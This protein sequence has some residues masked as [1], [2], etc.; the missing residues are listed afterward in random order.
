[1]TYRWLSQD[2]LTW[3][4]NGKNW[5]SS[6]EN[7]SPQQLYNYFNFIYS[8]QN[9]KYFLYRSYQKGREGWW[10]DTEPPSHDKDAHG[11]EK[12]ILGNV[13]AAIAPNGHFY[14]TFHQRRVD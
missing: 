8:I 10:I 14:F 6:I 13:D 3:S 1:M 11:T 9:G 7:P 12:K 2:T 4:A 5:I